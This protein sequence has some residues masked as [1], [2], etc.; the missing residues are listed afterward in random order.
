MMSGIDEFFVGT[1]NQAAKASQPTPEVRFASD[2]MFSSK[3]FNFLM[4]NLAMEPPVYYTP[5]LYKQLEAFATVVKAWEHPLPVEPPIVVSIS[6]EELPLEEHPWAW[7][8]S[9][10][11]IITG[12]LPPQKH[13]KFSNGMII[14][15]ITNY[16][17]KARILILLSQWL[18]IMHICKCHS[19]FFFDVLKQLVHFFINQTLQRKC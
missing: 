16:I 15:I 2:Y 1:L 7:D 17:C 4:K 3:A 18:S 13:Y 10:S 19:K 11:S 6:K 14:E 5:S 9:F 12:T 8:G